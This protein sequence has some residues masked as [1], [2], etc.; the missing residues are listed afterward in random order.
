MFNLGDPTQF[1]GPETSGTAFFTYGITWA[2]NHGIPRL[3]DLRPVVTK[4]W[5]AMATTSVQASGSLGYV[6]GTG[7]SLPTSS[8]SP[9]S[10]TAAYGVGAFLLAGSELSKLCGGG[11]TCRVFGFGGW[12]WSRCGLGAVW[13]LV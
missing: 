12:L 7:R 5:Q 6:Q 4:A 11:L 8:R 2:I 3:R 9:P 10:S 1:P 13:A